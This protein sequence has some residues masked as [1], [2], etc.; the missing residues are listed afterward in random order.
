MCWTVE[1]GKKQFY[2]IGMCESSKF[3]KSWTLERGSF[4]IWEINM[5][6]CPPLE[7]DNIMFINCLGY[8]FY[9]YGAFEFLCNSIA[10][11]WCHV[12]Y[13]YNTLGYPVIIISKVIDISCNGRRNVLLNNYTID[14]FVDTIN[15]FVC[16]RIADGHSFL[17]AGTP[18]FNCIFLYIVKFGIKILTLCSLCQDT[19][20]TYKLSIYVKNM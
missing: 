15:G 14:K 7:Y 4:M 20:S 18:I 13:H 10:N 8:V 17:W 1:A 5:G 19:I 12:W 3:P 16:I 11:L 2:H 6:V 9:I